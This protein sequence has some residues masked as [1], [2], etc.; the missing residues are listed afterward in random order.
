MTQES[1]NLFIY[2]VF[3]RTVDLF[4]ILALSSILYPLGLM[5]AFL[6]TLICDAFNGQSIGKRIFNLIVLDTITNTPIDYKQSAIRNVPFALCVL[7]GS[8]FFLWAFLVIIG[9]PLI[10]LETYLLFTLDARTRL[11]DIL[12]NTCVVFNS[13]KKASD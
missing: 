4:I 1:F 9:I 2:R 7:F 13:V 8:T 6:Y 10:L 12:A 3:A 5:V 11:G